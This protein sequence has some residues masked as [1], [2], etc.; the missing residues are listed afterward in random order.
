MSQALASTDHSAWYAIWTRSR[1][2]R[3]VYGQLVAK[4]IDAFLPTAMRWS[5]WTDRRKQ[6]E[7]PLFPGYC[8]AR[9]DAVHTLP[10]LR[11]T[12]AVK[13]ISVNGIPAPIPD[14][15][16]NSLRLVVT[17]RLQ[18]DP[19]SLIEEG[20][21]VEIVRGPLQGVVGKL[22]RKE[23]NSATVIVSVD[24]I[25]QGVRLKVHIGDITAR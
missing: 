16:I 3:T 17:S 4:N 1:H 12:G 7:Q 22:L 8:F 10:V 14:A 19:C 21:T 5:Q 9:F 6:I 23:S 20:T 15:E 18:C 24:L 2:E 11:C 13:V 25:S